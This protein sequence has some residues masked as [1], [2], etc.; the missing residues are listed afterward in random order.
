VADTQRYVIL[1][2]SRTDKHP[3]IEP[4]I[5][6][7][8]VKT[9]WTSY[10]NCIRVL[11]AGTP[12]TR[13]EASLINQTQVDLYDEHW[14]VLRDK[15]LETVEMALTA[16]S[17]ELNQRSTII[18]RIKLRFL[19]TYDSGVVEIGDTVALAAVYGDDVDT[20][21]DADVRIVSLSRSFTPNGERVDAEAVNYVKANEF[22]NY[23]GSVNDLLRWVVT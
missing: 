3:T 10:V 2:N 5:K 16:A 8:D 15:D 4:N 18:Q 7:V 23:L 17:N 6:V 21:I 22:Y 1:K 12:P 19:D 13:A 20:E 14:G 9:D 11:G